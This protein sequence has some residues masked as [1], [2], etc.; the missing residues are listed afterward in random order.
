MFEDED[1]VP[2]P[3][4]TIEHATVVTIRQG[5]ELVVKLA[6]A[7]EPKF[8]IRIRYEEGYEPHL[9][10]TTNFPDSTERNGVIYDVGAW[11]GVLPCCC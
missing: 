2:E 7:E 11:D 6:D 5:S 8:E 4:V 9:T 10:I 1:Y 3:K